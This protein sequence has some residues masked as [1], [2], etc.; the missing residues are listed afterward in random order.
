MKEYRHWSGL[1]YLE[2]LRPQPGWFVEHAVLAT[3]SAD[4]VAIVAV[5]LALA[6]LDDDRGSGSKVHFATA[7][8]Q[9]RD[10]M[11]VIVQAGRISLPGKTPSI[12]TILDRF[13]REVKFDESKLSWH[14]KVALI[15][16]RAGVLDDIEWRLW[17]GS[18]NLT[19]DLSW[20]VGLLLIGNANGNGY[21]IPGIVEIGEELAS[22]SGLPHFRPENAKRD[23][24]K[25]RWQGPSGVKVEEIRLLMPDSTRG[26]PPP[27]K[28]L[29]KLV[30]VSP[31]I[32]GTSIKELGKWGDGNTHR[33]LLSAPS[34]LS[35]LLAQGGKPLSNYDDIL[36][37]DAPES[38]GTAPH[39][40]I[41][42][43][44]DN[45]PS[46]GEELESRGLHAKLIYTEHRGGQTLWLGSPNITTRG[47][48]SNIE[49]IA[50]LSLNPTAAEGLSAFLHLAHTE[51]IDGIPVDVAKD[52]IEERLEKAR[53]QVAAGWQVVQRR[54]PKGPI[55]IAE[56]LPHPK[57][58]DIQLLVGNFGGNF[59]PWP[60]GR[61]KLQLA[62]IQLFQESEIIKVRLCLESFQCTWVQQ[63]PLDPPPNEDR[64][65]RAI[66][67]YLEPR[68]FLLWIRSLL[69]SGDIESGGGDWDS[70]PSTPKAG[71]EWA[72]NTAS[73]WAPTLE[74]ILK[75]W[76]RDPKNLCAV[77]N[78]IR[79]YL[80]FMQEQGCDSSPEEKRAISDFFQV[81]KILCK[82]LISKGSHDQT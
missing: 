20:D 14:P 1:P 6:G 33:T 57:D 78:K 60:R 13:I 12:L 67:R 79:H 74:D 50:R 80:K 40:P 35:K 82:E 15:K 45:L 55:M 23:L 24:K 56:E 11:R 18:K 43:Y 16:L 71:R 7:I 53:K 81:W 22:R 5:L 9:L 19:R 69:Q 61:H 42:G 66:A 27:P 47:W 48:R 58:R 68:N 34:E 25:V 49:V 4:L 64:D 51:K 2:A 46:D 72:S 26:L 70:E 10:R 39:P 8:E 75:S 28:G 44:E 63:S 17:I 30:A 3:Y 29:K 59:I 38:E 21:E 52:L 54:H 36:S 77:D 65:R 73:I 41:E 32:D 76:T 37:L 62:S 31:F